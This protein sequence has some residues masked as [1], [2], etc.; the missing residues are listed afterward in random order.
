MKDFINV[1]ACF[2]P[3]G[4]DA[5]GR[6]GASLGAMAL[7]EQFD[8]A[9]VGA[10]IAGASAAY[11]LA[12]RGRVL[13]LERERMPGQHTTGRSAAF[14]VDTYGGPLVQHLTRASRDFLERP[15]EGFAT[16]PLVKAC[17]VMWVARED[18]QARLEA[19]LEQGLASGAS[20][21]RLAIDEARAQCP[22]LRSE[23]IVAAIA[24][25]NAL[26]IDVAGL[27]AAFL[28]GL[29]SRGGVLASNSSVERLERS[30]GGWELEAGGRDFRSSV[31]VNAAG[32]WCDQV[33]Q[34]AGAR[35][36]GLVPMRR[37]AIT[38]EP[39]RGADIRGWPCVIDADEEFYVKP[40]GRGQLLASPCDETPCEPCDASPDELDIALAIDR[41][42]GAL[43]LEVKHIERSW[44]GLRTFAPDRSPVIGMDPASEGFFWLAGQGGFGIMT[45]PAASR[46][47]ASLIVDGALPAELADRG[48]RGE[49]LSPSRFA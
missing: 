25:T 16:H 4:V 41:L 18:Q 40:E 26:S 13:L 32:A 48:L 44:A 19:A 45:S 27:L 11:E 24:E 20:L 37:T 36:L 38:F 42:Q 31:V 1:P 2:I 28:G 33:A 34:R 43:A 30:G 10:G 29:R 3:H 21:R 46:T 12:A 17:P 47:A 22:V 49:Q 5:S 39:P 8:F 6:A 15:P 9:V 7:P 14:L 23:R 35:A